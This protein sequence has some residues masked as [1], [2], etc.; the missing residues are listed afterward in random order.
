MSLDTVIYITIYYILYDTGFFIYP[1]T[2]SLS[3]TIDTSSND[4]LQILDATLDDLM[5]SIH[6]VYIARDNGLGGMSRNN[7]VFDSN[8]YFELWIPCYMV[9]NNDERRPGISRQNSKWDN[10]NFIS[11]KYSLPRSSNGNYDSDINSPEESLRAHLSSHNSTKINTGAHENEMISSSSATIMQFLSTKPLRILLMEDS[12]LVQKI[13]C[14]L[15]HQ[16]G[17]EVKIAKNGRLGLELLQ[18]EEFDIAL[19]DFVMPIQDGV[20]TMKMFKAWMDQMR[21]ER[22]YRIGNQSTLFCDVLIG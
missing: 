6:G 17:C 13:I 19:I 16:R 5:F 8:L 20:T 2:T 22:G 10:E 14:R 1:V 4:M 7:A 21:K 12:V 15:L 18:N 9:N 3:P 11:E